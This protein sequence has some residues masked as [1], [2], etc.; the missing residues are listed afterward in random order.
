M[1]KIFVFLLTVVVLTISALAISPDKSAKSL[2]C[3]DR[4]YNFLDRDNYIAMYAVNEH[5]ALIRDDNSLWMFGSN[6]D[7]RLGIG[8]ERN[9][10]NAPIKV[11]EN[12]E[13][14]KIK[15]K[16]TVAIKRDGSMW[17]FGLN[18]GKVP[19]KLYDN[20]IDG[21]NNGIP[22][23]INKSGDAYFK[24]WNKDE[25]FL[26]SGAKEIY[27]LDNSGGNG[28]S[29]QKS[30]GITVNLNDIKSYLSKPEFFIVV[31]RENGELYEY[32]VNSYGLMDGG[33]LVKSGV[34]KVISSTDSGVT[35]KMK[36]GRTL[37]G[38]TSKGLS[39]INIPEGVEYYSGFYKKADGTVWR[40]ATNECVGKNVKLFG[41]VGGGM[42]V[43]MVHNDNS[44]SA[45]SINSNVENYQ[46]RLNAINGSTA[47]MSRTPEGADDVKAK[48]GEICKGETDAYINAK[49]ISKW[50]GQNIEYDVRSNLWTGT[51][52]FRKGAGSRRSITDLTKTMLSFADIPVVI[53][54][55][56]EEKNAW[57][58]ALIDGVVTF[59]DNMGDYT[60]NK[61]D[62]GIFS[63]HIEDGIDYSYCPYDSWA[64]TEVRGAYDWDLIDRSLYG[65]YKNPIKRDEFCYIVRA[66]IERA[67][68]KSIDSVIADMDKSGVPYPFTDTTDPDVIAMYKLGIVNGT[69]ATAYTPKKNITREEAAKIMCGLA[70]ILGEETTATPAAFADSGNISAW[71]RDS[72]NFVTNRGI[73]KGRPTG[74]DP[75]NTISVQESI[76]ICYRYLGTVIGA[77]AVSTGAEILWYNEEK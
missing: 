18:A 40:Q 65:N 72:V 73:M 36:D 20:V 2:V 48:V 34:E 69:S 76:I 15:T 25:E 13:R 60:E 59:I 8:G 11:L 56:I 55:S 32:G 42:G 45:Y 30:G 39:E 57:N 26:C 47:I 62:M 23:Y 74:F 16:S 19:T 5:V 24:Y 10:Y 68:G 6:L 66:T 37:I 17:A 7:S 21:D 50:I 44:V 3:L 4:K 29:V 33:A 67:K 1:K 52:A 54:T 12:V 63:Q 51:D 75:K 41:V 77:S 71:A 27:V 46:A 64:A 53:S 28:L 35:L 49:N 70:R 22:A 61:F 31:L 38:T 9:A 58:I 14:V 43:F